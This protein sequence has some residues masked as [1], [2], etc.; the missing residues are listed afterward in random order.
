MWRQG[1]FSLV[2]MMIAVALGIVVVAGMINLFIANRKAYDIQSNNNFLQEDLRIASD[3]LGW[4]LRMADFWGGVAPT[5]VG[6]SSAGT[7]VTANGNCNE[8][9]VTAI[10]TTAAA[11]GGG[12][13]GYDGAD[14]FPMDANCIGGAA[15]YMPGTSVVVTR[16]ADSQVLA[17]GPA[18]AGVA[19]AEASTISNNPKELFV[20]AVPNV[21]A[22]LF[23]GAVPTI[24][25]TIPAYAYAYQLNMFYLRPCSVPVGGGNTCSAAADGG[26][27]LP[28]LMR[29]YLK[30]DGTLVSEPVVDGIEQ[31]NIEYGVATDLS[32][33]IT[34]T[35]YTA[36]EVTNNGTWTNVVSVRVSLVAV[37]PTRDVSVPHTFTA[38]L[39]TLGTCTYTINNNAAPTTTDCPNF[40]PYGDKS[41]QFVRT[42]QQFVV[43][44]RNRVE[45]N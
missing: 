7:T 24:G 37:N 5:S 43:A 17:P 21:S 8:A 35:Y 44:L 22:Q 28:T 29:M 40:T 42:Q 9:W 23:T 34:P 1:G 38:T 11:G 18:V 19:P 25:G 4:S 45:G 12:V 36:A 32:N 33:N 20:E 26:M 14:A 30:N 10:T 16:F 3:R 39:G 15:N 27:P 2:E 31:M 41:W 13:Y 6:T